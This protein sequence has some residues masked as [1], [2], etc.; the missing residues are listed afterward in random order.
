MGART[1]LDQPGQILED[2][3]ADAATDVLMG[4]VKTEAR[5]RSSIFSAAAG[6]LS[7]YNSDAAKAAPRTNFDAREFVGSRGTVYVSAP[8]HR[9]AACAPLVVGLLEQLRHATYERSAA[10]PARTVD[11]GAGLCSSVLTSWRT[12]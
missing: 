1:E 5:E 4:V 8:A 9:Q 12:S 7:A 6:V 10:V 11:M 3:A 2:H